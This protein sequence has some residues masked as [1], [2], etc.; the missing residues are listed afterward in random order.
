M[1][2][3]LARF[4]LSHNL[5]VGPRQCLTIALLAE[6]DVSTVNGIARAFKLT[7]PAVVT[8]LAALQRKGF[9]VKGGVSKSDVKGKPPATYTLTALGRAFAKRISQIEGLGNNFAVVRGHR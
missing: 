8:V 4:D 2:N 7:A 3:A 6:R 9:V 1:R 5:S